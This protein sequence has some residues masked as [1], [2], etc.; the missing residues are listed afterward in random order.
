LAVVSWNPGRW[1]VALNCRWLVAKSGKLKSDAQR[2][3]PSKFCITSCSH[4]TIVSLIPS[5]IKTQTW[6]I[7][8]QNLIRMDP[9]K[10]AAF[11]LICK[12]IQYC[13][14]A[15]CDTAPCVTHRFHFPGLLETQELTLVISLP[16]RH[17]ELNWAIPFR[18]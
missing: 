10:A 13:D 5:L 9:K 6:L 11:R 15:P 4:L 17:P 3:Y 1:G 14:T 2:I 7:T 8:A 18:R 16:S 12:S